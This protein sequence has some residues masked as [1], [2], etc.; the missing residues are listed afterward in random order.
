MASWRLD[1]IVWDRFD[2]AQLDPKIVAIV[3]AAALVELNGGA[4]AH[5]LCR[6]FDGD[7]AFQAAARRWGEDEVRHGQAL[8]RWAG[9]ADPQFD[10]AAAFARFRAGYRIDFERGQSRRGSRAGEMV[11]RCI[12]ETGTSSYYTALRESVQEPVLQD[13]CRRIA[14]DEF[15]HYRLFR[16]KLLNC[17]EREPI[18]LWPRLR[19]AVGRLVEAQDDELAYAY[20]AANE[21]ALPYDRRRCSGTYARGSFALYREPH[22]ARAA[23]MIFK[24]V[25]LPA[26]SRL[27]RIAARLAWAALRRRAAW[28]A[29]AAT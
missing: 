26:D 6:V 9:L 23:K 16:R 25:G 11:A 13:I 10:V 7:P 18:G 4:Y 5:H 19:I 20:Y 8:G 1:D 24:A 29:Q 12:V 27:C 17:L 3:K 22:I 14:A 28:L 15:R 21:T 2:R